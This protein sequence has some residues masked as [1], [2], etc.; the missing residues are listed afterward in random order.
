MGKPIRITGYLLNYAL[1][2]NGIE[3]DEM[4]NFNLYEK[5][6]QDVEDRMDGWNYDECF[7]DYERVSV[8]KA[9]LDMMCEYIINQFKDNQIYILIARVEDVRI[10]RE[11]NEIIIDMIYELSADWE[12]MYLEA[13]G[14]K[15]KGEL[16]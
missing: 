2:N 13:F 7:T 4:L 1:D 11:N 6:R 10:D 16:L 5:F 9:K 14:E 8:D 3:Y 12:E 15:P